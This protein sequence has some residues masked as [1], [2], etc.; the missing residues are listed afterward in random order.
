MKKKCNLIIGSTGFIGERVCKII[1]KK[2]DLYTI[3]KKNNMSFSKK[4]FLINTEKFYQLNKVISNLKKKYE[5]INVFFLAGESSVEN[6]IINSRLSINSSVISFH[7]LILC[8]KNFNST[9]IFASSGSVYDSREKSFFSE[10]DPLR[11]PSPYASIKYASEGMAMSYCETFGMDIRIARMFSVFGEKM[12]R[13]FIYDLV[14]KLKKSNGKIVLKG[15]GNQERD[16]LH[17]DD[18]AKGLITILNN[19]TKGEVYNLC[20]GKA[21]K[22][23]DLS[24]KIR[25]IL[26]KNEIKIVWDK[27]SIK[28]IRDCWYGKN[29]KIKSIGFNHKISFNKSLRSTINYIY[30]KL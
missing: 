23:K 30:K 4:H 8:L 16:Y 13:F 2:I 7:N 5:K 26:N 27:K 29:K 1:S 6:S 18:V 21:V 15:S 25:N 11:P 22:L 12:N 10:N 19:G 3:S 17:V 20:S 9:I 14:K 24:K 28:G